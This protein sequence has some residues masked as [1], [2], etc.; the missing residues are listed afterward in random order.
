MYEYIFHYLI[1]Y[2]CPLVFSILLSITGRGWRDRLSELYSDATLIS[3]R[4][5][6]HRSAPIA[7]IRTLMG[8]KNKGDVLLDEIAI[9]VIRGLRGNRLISSLNNRN[10][11]V[12]LPSAHLHTLTLMCDDNI[13]TSEEGV[14]VM[15]NDYKLSLTDLYRRMDIYLTIILALCAF[16][17]ILGLVISLFVRSHVVASVMLFIQIILLE[18][19][20]KIGKVK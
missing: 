19:I 12:R 20:G 16:I 7:I 15:L 8:K 13:E 9:N 5:V 14:E 3:F 18:V 4:K 11:R 2:L 6:V 10:S 17:P 1:A